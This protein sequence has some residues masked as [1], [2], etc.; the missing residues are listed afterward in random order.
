MT[1]VFLASFLNDVRKI[2]DGRVR[3]AIA[4]VIEQV[5]RANDVTG[6]SQLKRLSGWRLAHRH[7]YLR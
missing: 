6:I 4:R 2:R 3:A 7:S 1:T 5:E